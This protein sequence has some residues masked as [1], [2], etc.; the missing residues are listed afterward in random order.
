[1]FKHA[2]RCDE[3]YDLNRKKQMRSRSTVYSPKD[4][5]IA[6]S[7]IAG[8]PAPH[9]WADEQCSMVTIFLLLVGSGLV[10]FTPCTK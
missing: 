9:T 2:I 5:K 6:F 4:I 3:T 8:A 10:T 1:M 7:S